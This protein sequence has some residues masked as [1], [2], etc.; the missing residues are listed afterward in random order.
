[1]STGFLPPAHSG[2]EASEDLLQC[3]AFRFAIKAQGTQQHEGHVVKF[4][5][6]T[7][8]CKHERVFSNI[9]RMHL[10]PKVQETCKGKMRRYLR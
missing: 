7:R 5:Y 6:R 4:G 1:M 8:L 10:H 9:L 2:N 3:A